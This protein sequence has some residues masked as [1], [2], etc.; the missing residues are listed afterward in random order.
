MLQNQTVGFRLNPVNTDVD[1]HV[2]EVNAVFT[3]L[4][5]V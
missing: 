4:R 1:S 3:T 5:A 2:Q